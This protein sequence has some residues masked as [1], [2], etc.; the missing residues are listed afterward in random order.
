[1]VRRC[2]HESDWDDAWLS[3]G[4]ATYFAQLYDEHYV[5]HDQFMTSVRGMFQRTLTI[6]AQSHEPVVHDNIAEPEL[7]GVIAQQGYQKGGSVLHMLRVHRIITRRI[8]M[9]THRPTIS[10]AHSRKRRGR[11]CAGSSRNGCTGPPIR[12]STAHGRSIRPRKRSP[13]N[14][15]RRRPVSRTVS[16]SSWESGRTAALSLE[17]RKSN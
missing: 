13:S 15:V 6:V 11:T 1:M 2:R 8:R 9:A 14:S 16:H 7:K 5:G 3:E 17:S 10:V 4:F 12:R